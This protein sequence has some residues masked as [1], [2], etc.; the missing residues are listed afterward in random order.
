MAS[1]G[2]AFTDKYQA[3]E[4]YADTPMPTKANFFADP[5]KAAGEIIRDLVGSRLAISRTEL[6]QLLRSLVTKGEPV[7][8]R[9]G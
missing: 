8:D 6:I 7:D 3:G 4:S 1:S 5:V 2:T 9:K